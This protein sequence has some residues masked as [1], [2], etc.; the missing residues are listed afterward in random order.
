MIH[1]LKI[2]DCGLKAELKRLLIN[3]FNKFLFCL[4]SR[5]M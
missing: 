3:I 1:A 4:L 2:E 5:D